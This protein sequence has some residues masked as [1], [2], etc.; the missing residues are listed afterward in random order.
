MFVHE[1][2]IR[3]HVPIGNARTSAEQSCCV[4]PTSD[5]DFVTSNG[6]PLRKL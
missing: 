5:F 6:L 1:N 2:S 4:Q 3:F